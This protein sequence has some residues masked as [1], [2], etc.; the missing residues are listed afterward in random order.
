MTGTTLRGSYPRGSG[1]AV[2]Q[3]LLERPHEGP[4]TQRHPAKLARTLKNCS[5]MLTGHRSRAGQTTKPTKARPDQRTTTGQGRGQGQGQ[6]LPRAVHRQSGDAKCAASAPLCLRPHRFGHPGPSYG[7]SPD[8]VS[9]LAVPRLCA[10]VNPGSAGGTN[11]ERQDH[12]QWQ[13]RQA[14]DDRQRGTEGRH[15]AGTGQGP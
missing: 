6:G 5:G 8:Q 7:C 10:Y 12:R 3:V 13:E 9:Q 4:T 2:R 1:H 11:Y 14:P 15:L